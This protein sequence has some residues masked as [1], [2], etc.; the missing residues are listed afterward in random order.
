MALI[1]RELCNVYQNRY[2]TIQYDRGSLTWTVE[3]AV[4]QIS[5]A[6]EPKQI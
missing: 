3:L 5:L 1:H 4:Y 2:D 6:H